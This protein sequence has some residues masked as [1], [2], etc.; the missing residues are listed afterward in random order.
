MKKIVMGGVVLAACTAM[1]VGA[2]NV[3]AFVPGEEWQPN[4]EDS[5]T[6]TGSGGTKPVE[7]KIEASGTFYE[8]D[9]TDPNPDP[10]DPIP[11]AG[12]NAWI[13][14][15]LPEKILFGS[16][17][18][19]GSGENNPENR[20]ISSPRYY[21]Q[22]DSAK[23]VDIKVESIINTKT[24]KIGVSGDEQDTNA[25]NLNLDMVLM[26]KN[27]NPQGDKITLLTDDVTNED[28][29]GKIP[30][31]VGGERQ[32]NPENR[33]QYF[34]LQGTVD[35]EFVFLDQHRRVKSVWNILFS[36]STPGNTI[37]GETPSEQP[38]P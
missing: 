16:A 27:G 28:V 9:P 33:R 6:V 1:F 5:Q 32:S 31:I 37:N 15:F 19:P 17:Y 24:K 38:Q 21:I 10:T 23:P 8:F 14:V 20:N 7:S 34:E 12:D 2:S 30:Q 18:L 26:D 35:K 11:P 25:P 3:Y 22:N 4:E 13:S 36:F 29:D